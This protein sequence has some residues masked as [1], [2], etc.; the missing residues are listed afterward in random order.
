LNGEWERAK[1]LAHRAESREK[2]SETVR[3]LKAQSWKA[4]LN[5]ELGEKL[6]RK[7]AKAAKIFKTGK[8]Y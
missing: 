2:R 7:D 3:K 8:C 4:I 5:F 1:R 6:N